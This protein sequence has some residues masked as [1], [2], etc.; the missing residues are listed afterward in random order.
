MITRLIPLT[1]K[2]PRTPAPIKRLAALFLLA[3]PLCAGGIQ[4]DKQLHLAAGF[5]IGGG[6]TWIAKE[7]GFKYPELWGS[8]A[9]IL[10]GALKEALDRRHAGNHWDTRDL[11]HTAGAGIVISFSF[12]F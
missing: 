4:K 8:F 5:L 10:A 7:Q 1:P 11:A 6:V 3:L 2:P 9:S 12:K